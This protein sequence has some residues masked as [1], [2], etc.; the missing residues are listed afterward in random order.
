MTASFYA[1]PVPE[2][3]RLKAADPDAERLNDFLYGPQDFVLV[4]EKSLGDIPLDEEPLPGPPQLGDVPL[5]EEPLPELLPA[6]EQPLAELSA[7]GD[8]AAD[9]SDPYPREG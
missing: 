9:G 8:N 3:E 4:A 2:D 7:D 1:S 5:D 6:G